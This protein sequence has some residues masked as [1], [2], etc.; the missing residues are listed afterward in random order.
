MR[1]NKSIKMKALWDCI[2]AFM[3]VCLVRQYPFLSFFG[4]KLHLTLGMK[5]ESFIMKITVANL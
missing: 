4:C 2:R 3:S 5:N 1:L